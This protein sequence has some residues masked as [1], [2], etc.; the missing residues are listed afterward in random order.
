MTPNV[1]LNII[2]GHMRP[3]TLSDVNMEYVNGL[4]DPEV[5]R[6]LDNASRSK[7]TQQSVLNFVR[8]NLQSDNSIL[9]GIW[10][11]KQQSLSGTVRLHGI[12]PHHG[13]A[14]IGVCLFNKATW[15]KGLGSY[16]I[17]AVTQWAM[18]YLKL[19]WIEAGVYEENVISQRAFVKAGYE[20]ISDISGKYLLGG[21][22][23]KVKIYAAH[24]NTN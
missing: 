24:K 19:R 9:W 18:Q 15:G 10:L 1:Q 14:S 7:H 16:A 5:N 3:L 20:F 6:Y 23:A 22:P 21:K 13:V 8:S 4:N 17:S 11:T 12:D 2:G